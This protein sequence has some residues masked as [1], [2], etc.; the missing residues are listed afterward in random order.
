MT[1]YPRSL[2]LGHIPKIVP[3]D[4]FA[5]I[6]EEPSKGS[7][8]MTYLAI[9][10]FSLITAFS[11]SSETMQQHC[12]LPSRTLIQTSLEMISSFFYTSPVVF[13]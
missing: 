8:A 9:L 4:T 10:F 2:F 3:I 11:F 1:G 12:P 13:S 7:I 6:L 5:S